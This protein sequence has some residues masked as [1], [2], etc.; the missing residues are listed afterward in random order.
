MVLFQASTHT[1]ATC[2]RILLG[3]IRPPPGRQSRNESRE[4]DNTTIA[5]MRHNSNTIYER[6]CSLLC[7]LADLALSISSFLISPFSARACLVVDVASRILQHVT[8]HF[9]AYT[10]SSILRAWCNRD[11]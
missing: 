4:M 8:R 5:L 9:Q 6:R 10:T 2:M 11:K 3:S 7:S 1:T